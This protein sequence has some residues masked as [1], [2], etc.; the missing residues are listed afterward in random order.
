[1]LGVASCDAHDLRLFSSA[2]ASQ[3]YKLGILFVVLQIRHNA[4]CVTKQASYTLVS[5]QTSYTVSFK[6][7]ILQG[8]VTKQASTRCVKIQAF[9]NSGIQ[10]LW[11]KR[12]ILNAMWQSSLLT[13]RSWSLIAERGTGAGYQSHKSCCGEM[14]RFPWRRWKCQRH[15]GARGRKAHLLN[16]TPTCRGPPL[17][18]AVFM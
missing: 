6:S 13:S 12:A 11:Y 9:Y 4:R 14:F 5:N 7:D 16:R 1:M 18:Y 10:T 8:S 15:K 3:W 17:A 2:N